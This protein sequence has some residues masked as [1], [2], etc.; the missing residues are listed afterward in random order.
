LIF[1]IAFKDQIENS[2]E[3]E[4]STY[5]VIAEDY[6]EAQTTAIIMHIKESCNPGICKPEIDHEL[7]FQITCASDKNGILYNIDCARSLH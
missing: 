1:L 3:T 7:S 4:L 2:D 5:V 6:E